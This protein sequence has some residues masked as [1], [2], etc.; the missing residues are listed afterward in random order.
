MKFVIKCTGE[1]GFDFP[2]E[3]DYADYFP[4][5]TPLSEADEPA[6]VQAAFP[7]GVGVF[8]FGTF[9][10]NAVFT[11]KTIDFGYT[12]PFVEEMALIVAARTGRPTKWYQVPVRK[13]PESRKA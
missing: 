13:A 2:E 9:V 8:T 12:E 10:V 6:D 4:A 3:I 1:D 7:W 11:Y 5:G